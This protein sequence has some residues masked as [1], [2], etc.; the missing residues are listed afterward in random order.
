MLTKSGKWWIREDEQDLGIIKFTQDHT[1][2]TFELHGRIIPRIVERF[3]GDAPKRTALDI[4]SCYGMIA[5]PLSH[6]FN[7]VYSFEPNPRVW[8]AFIKNTRSHNNIHLNRVGI[9][10]ENK[11][12]KFQSLKFSGCSHISTEGNITVPVKSIDSFN[13]TNVDLIK[14][15]VEGHEL[16]VIKGAI[17]LLQRDKPLLLVEI[18]ENFNHT[19]NSIFELGYCM[20]E[21]ARVKDFVFIHRDKIVADFIRGARL[22]NYN[23]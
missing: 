22:K 4:G 7:T 21:V 16:D 14:I 15:D 18:R 12:I 19:L 6:Y 5:V 13:F 17:D 10:S 20:V 1:E 2:S 8:D 11:E 3:L 23:F 9:S